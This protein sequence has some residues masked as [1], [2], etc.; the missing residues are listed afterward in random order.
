MAIVS[1]RRSPRLAAA[2]TPAR[3]RVAAEPLE[4]RQLFAAVLVAPLPN[5]SG[6]AGGT[7]TIDLSPY[8][9][10]NTTTFLKF[11]TELGTY[12]VQLF[13]AQKPVTVQNFLSYVNQ[14]RLND[15][16]IHRAAD[17]ASPGGPA[18]IIQGGGFKLPLISNGQFATH[19][20][21]DA[22]IVNE[23]MTNGLI[24]NTRGTIAMARTSD[25]NSATSEWF[26][27]VVDNTVLDPNA[28]NSPDGYAV[29]GK[30]T[31]ADLPVIDAIAALPRFPIASQANSTFGEIPLRNYTQSDLSAAK[32]PGADN[33]VTT[34]VA[35]TGDVVTDVMQVTA[36]SSNP[37][38]VTPTVSNGNLVLAYAPGAVG[39]ADIT[40]TATSPGGNTVTSTFAATAS[41]LQVTLGGDT[42]NKTAVFTDADGTVTTV[43]FKG[44]GT[45]TLGFAGDNLSQTG[46]GKVTVAGTISGLDAIALT[47]SDTSTTV[48]ITS[49]GGDGVSTLAG[50]TSQG[51]VKSVTGKT[52]RL[53]GPMSIAGTLGSLTL[54][55]AQNATITVGGAST[56]KPVTLAIGE[57]T[58]SSVT[59]ASPIKSLKVTTA[60]NADATVSE[61]VTAPAIASITSTGNF[62]TDVTIPGEG[63]LT[64]LKVGG[65][66]TGD[67]T[68]HAIGTISVKGAVSGATITATHAAGEDDKTPGIKAFTVTGGL[69][70]TTINSAG[71]IVGL[72]AGSV[73][74][75]TRIVA[76]ATALTTGLPTSTADFTSQATIKSIKVKTAF[77]GST[78]VASTIKTVKLGTLTLA[79]GGVPFGFAADNIGAITGR[80]DANKKFAV[81]SPNDQ[82]QA[83]NQLNDIALAD[84]VFLVL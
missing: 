17:I 22:P 51:E 39:S 78:V 71:D 56:A 26:V 58:D 9:D 24:S 5:T 77:S 81:R 70:G 31:A 54:G 60:A 48:T 8:F 23:T 52:T 4:A 80:T 20:P 19:I 50:L 74:G 57:L 3:P 68:A 69:A 61:A 72:S 7:Q 65:D 55:G 76:G 34:D 35:V 1:R 64:S 13:D 44:S 62:G 84:A 2:V 15:T 30:V 79:N 49:K 83:N 67:V 21:G 41:G 82:T 28:T 46:T 75:G 38:L 36:T 14:G 66:L 12:R 10:E 73:T 53:T 47:G 32:V 43:A 27:N 18:D 45:A 63:N 37:A 6:A 42:A 29:F 33:A 59:S 25:P 16:V 40:V 11:T